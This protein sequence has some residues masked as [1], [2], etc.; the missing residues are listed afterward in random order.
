MER[1]LVPIVVRILHSSA[2]KPLL[3][4]LSLAT[5]SLKLVNLV[6][7]YLQLALVPVVPRSLV[8]VSALLATTLA[9]SVVPSDSNAWI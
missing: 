4:N 6:V 8:A 1:R 7:P 5:P 9:R 2:L 3:V